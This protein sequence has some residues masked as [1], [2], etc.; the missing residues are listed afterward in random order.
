MPTTCAGSGNWPSRT[1]GIVKPPLKRKSVCDAT[2]S[3][4][5]PSRLGRW[6]VNTCSGPAAI[7]SMRR[8][9]ARSR[10]CLG[11]ARSVAALLGSKDGWLLIARSPFP[12]TTTAWHTTIGTCGLT[13]RARLPPGQVCSKA[14]QQ[15]LL[16]LWRRWNGESPR[17]LSAP[18]SHG[19]PDL[20]G[21]V[22]L[23]DGSGPTQGRGA[24]A[25]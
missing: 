15:S 3:P 16:G 20:R 10:D 22:I 13:R 6:H 24:H 23:R 19:H 11:S 17:L 25:F 9:R 21:L 5:R 18:A 4:V 7:T 1:R 14:T 2:S 8:Q 12:M